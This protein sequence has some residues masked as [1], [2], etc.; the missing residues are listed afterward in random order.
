MGCKFSASL[1][2]NR[3]LAQT[4]IPDAN[5]KIDTK[6]RQQSPPPESVSYQ[7]S[8]ERPEERSQSPPP[9]ANGKKLN[10]QKPEGR[11]IDRIKVER[12]KTGIMNRINLK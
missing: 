12:P 10:L 11:I 2:N 5:S 9:V 6:R 8:S 7:S 1:R 3:Q 4:S